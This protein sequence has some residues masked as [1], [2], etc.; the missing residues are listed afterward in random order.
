MQDCSLKV[1]THTASEMSLPRVSCS[2]SGDRV[3]VW[4]LAG[5][6]PCGAEL[7]EQGRGKVR[8]DGTGDREQRARQRMSTEVLPRSL[9]PYART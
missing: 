6:T 9:D 7:P 2:G 3:H 1:L 4:A 8:S 5:P